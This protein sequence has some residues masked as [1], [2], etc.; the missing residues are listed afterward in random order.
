MSKISD[1]LVAVFNLII[2]IKLPSQTVN[3][4]ELASLNL[5]LPLKDEVLYPRKLSY[6]S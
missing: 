6:S 3:N 4:I 1:L 2:S 5:I